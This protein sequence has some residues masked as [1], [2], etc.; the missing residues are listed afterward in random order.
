MNQHNLALNVTEAPVV[1][2]LRKRLRRNILSKCF[3]WIIVSVASSSSK[4]CAAWLS[5]TDVSVCF[6]AFG[7][8]LQ[9]S[10]E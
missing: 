9:Y 3:H 7:F 6:N 2:D 4:Q 5:D 1:Q 8:L 10:G